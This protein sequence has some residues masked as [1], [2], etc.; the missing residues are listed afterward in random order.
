[1]HTHDNTS[2]ADCR[3]ATGNTS[4]EGVGSIGTVSDLS[5]GN[6]DYQVRGVTAVVNALREGGRAQLRMACGTGKT[7]MAL[8]TAQ[9]LTGHAGVVVIVV[10]TVGLVEQTLRVW[11]HTHTDHWALAVCSDD[12]VQDDG[13][14]TDDILE[15]VTTDPDVIAAWLRM[16]TT[17]A[18]RLI[19]GTHISAHVIGEG[20][21][22]AAATAELL[23]IDE[24]HRSAGAAEK[25]S[26]LVHEDDVLPARRRLYMTAT[27]RITL[28]GHHRSGT[29]ST[30][31][32][33]TVLSMD[34]ETVF[35]P[36]AFNY[37]FSQAIADGWLDDYRLAVIG[38]TQA[39]VL[40]MLARAAQ[41]ATAHPHQP[42]EHTAMVHAALAR[43]AADLGL[44]RVIAFCPRVRDAE[45]FART[46]PRS[47][48]AL[49]PD[50][51][52]GRRLFA[53]HIHG[54]MNTAGR[55]TLLKH[56]ADPGEQGWTVISNAKCL[57]EGIDVPTV[58][59]VVFTAP[60][61]STVDIVQAVGRAL[62]RDPSGTGTATILVPIL[63]PDEPGDVEDVI[64]AGA[65]DT[66]W[67]VVRALRAHDDLFGAALDNSRASG[68]TDT[69][70]R[71]RIAFTLPEHYHNQFLQHLT[72]RLVRSA[73]DPWWD[74]YAHL[75]AVHAEL[76]HTR[77]STTHV[78]D[79][80]FK[81][82]VWMSSCRSAYRQNRLTPDRITALDKLGFEFDVRKAKA[83]ERWEKGLAV[84]T[85]F[86]AERGHLR[87]PTNFLR[88]GI[89][90]SAWLTACRRAAARGAL[91]SDRIAALDT[92]GMSWNQQHAGRWQER[93]GEFLDYHTHYGE[94]PVDRGP[95][96]NNRSLYKV[97]H[98]LRT[99]CRK[100]ELDE[101]LIRELDTR[102]FEW[103]P[104]TAGWRRGITAATAF[105]AKHGHL[106]PRP[107]DRPNG[108]DLWTWLYRLRQDRT[109]GKLPAD[110]IAALDDLGMIWDVN[111]AVWEKT[112]SALVAF[113]AEHGHVRV[114]AGTYVTDLWEQPL[115]LK[116]WVD[117]QR[118]NYRAGTLT[119]E[120]VAKLD[121]LGFDWHPHQSS[122]EKNL[123]QLREF[124]AEHGHLNI[125]D[126]PQWRNLVYVL[127]QCRVKYHAGTLP[128]DRFRALNSL[129]MIWEKN[130]LQWNASLAEAQQYH[131]EHGHLEIPPPKPNDPTTQRTLY[132][133]LAQNRRA[134]HEHRLAPWQIDA[135]NALNIDWGHASSREQKW[136]QKY[137][138]AKAFFDQN[139]HLNIPN[140]PS[141]REL[142]NWVKYQRSRQKDEKLSLQ[143]VQ[144]LT[145]IGMTWTL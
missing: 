68:F 77:I 128:T 106:L 123:R 59:G 8:W 133:W 83:D 139:G 27:A 115:H 94:F 105:H 48:A 24:A 89:R 23:V 129:G 16:P 143:Q 42:S 55:K 75:A 109:K 65:Y 132:N 5:P 97:A 39:D 29:R 93:I 15:P 131:A 26:G 56:L 100:G 112:F 17:S 116:R 7:N 45:H 145:K 63:L 95:N 125:P 126:T 67:E 84:A 76:G 130:A 144:L 34:N 4:D 137:S 10:P 107:S 121:S 90:L 120:R 33:P 62:R 86:H 64:D 46:F 104:R 134:Y 122:W 50:A 36:V 111:N 124:H 35:G 82:G 49:P 14:T 13:T 57:G 51:Q 101:Q 53:A 37:P 85:A 110:Q 66:L 87:P 91:P 32:A 43:A 61:R 78:T 113:H 2:A 102:G 81:L 41:T 80:G 69:A 54:G 44:R 12:S 21:Q 19:V 108:I 92:L 74:G 114:P 25:H 119:P 30:D 9:R 127:R 117:K 28:T 96:G 142:R 47:L 72:V 52:P 1:M 136:H 6:R 18:I 38:V 11:Q 22:K 3:A 103:D 20:L 141:Y 88:D 140:H 73:T 99:A 31:P 138:A 40:A 71:D 118:A 58:D 70:V 135:L 98:H 60:K 79:D